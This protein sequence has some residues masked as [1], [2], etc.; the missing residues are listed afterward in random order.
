MR[1]W[2]LLSASRRA[3]LAIVLTLLAVV[4]VWV[5]PHAGIVIGFAYPRPLRGI[6]IAELVGVILAAII[7]SLQATE[8]NVFE[9]LTRSR[10][11]ASLTIYS[12]LALG[13]PVIP[14][15]CWYQRIQETSPRSS[16][17]PQWPFAGTLLVYA[18]LGLLGVQALGAIW[19][20]IAMMIAFIGIAVS[21]HWWGP[22]F[23][24]GVLSTGK[25]WQT[26]WVLLAG[27]FLAVL[28]LTY[29]TRGVP[30]RSLST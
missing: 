8:F 29:Q 3:T 1:G 2:F 6:G 19:G 23:A 4:A 21:Q 15:L 17:P 18:L 5:W 26:N 10:A 7:P 12:A 9:A 30:G 11:R 25:V 22:N 27:L 20:P 14:F 16:L 24:A 13:L 28:A